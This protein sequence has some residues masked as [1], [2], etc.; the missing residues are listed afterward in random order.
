MNLNLD[1]IKSNTALDVT[2]ADIFSSS[3]H[4]HWQ[5]SFFSAHLCIFSEVL[6]G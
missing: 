5:Y 1:L 6:P 3:A 2:E 4:D